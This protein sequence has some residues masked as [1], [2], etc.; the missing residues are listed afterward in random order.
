MLGKDE[1]LAG[2]RS[3]RLLEKLTEYMGPI[4]ASLTALV[5]QMFTFKLESKFVQFFG[6]VVKNSFEGNGT[7]V[8]S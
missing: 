4:L 5:C 6:N 1:F 3:A 8:I 7:E 2:N